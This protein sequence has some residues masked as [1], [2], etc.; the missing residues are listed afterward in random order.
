MAYKIHYLSS[1][2]IKMHWEEFNQSCYN[3]PFWHRCRIAI[4]FITG[5]GTSDVCR[6]CHL[7]ALSVWIFSCSVI[8]A[9]YQYLR[10]TGASRTHPLCPRSIL[11]SVSVYRVPGTTGPWARRR[12]MSTY[13][14][15]LVSSSVENGSTR[16]VSVQI[17]CAGAMEGE[18]WKRC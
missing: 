12:F 11:I 16:A 2:I 5:H 7:L 10:C 17:S 8:N 1:R 13:V 14:I 4:T 9:V 3:E 18:R 15:Y 6:L